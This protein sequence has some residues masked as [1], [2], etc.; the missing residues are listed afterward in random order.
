MP[1]L[2]GKYSLTELAKS[3]N[4]TSAFINRIQRETG[5]GGKIGIKGQS[6]SFTASDVKIFQRI[7]ILRKLDFSFKDIKEIWNLEE[8]I[9]HLFVNSIIVVKQITIW[10]KIGLILHPN[11]VVEP[12]F[13]FADSNKDIVE[14]VEEYR[15]LFIKLR[16]F[17][18]EIGRRRDIFIKEVEETKSGINEI[19]LIDNIITDIR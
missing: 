11:E 8:S 7:K 16:Q 4:V 14:L 5:I 10:R 15:E 17:S 13:D 12:P 2:Y 3:L 6:A 9:A 19:G 18:K 1:N